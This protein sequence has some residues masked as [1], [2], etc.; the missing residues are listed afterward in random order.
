[1]DKISTLS[2]L[3]DT[4]SG[5][6]E[7]TNGIKE[8]ILNGTIPALESAKMLKSF[9]EIVKALR[10]DKDIKEYIQDEADLWNEKSVEYLGAKFTKTERPTYDFKECEDAE[11]K[12]TT[13]AIMQLKAKLKGR[14][15][16]LKSL[17]EPTP[18]IATGEVI[19]PPTVLKTSI[20]SVS[21]SK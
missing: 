20:V 8:E 21:L 5:I 2:I 17:K 3:P 11:W 14:E 7:Y 15:D 4:K 13:M 12:E 18:D 16:W 9:E 1:M 6:L 19:N 10:G